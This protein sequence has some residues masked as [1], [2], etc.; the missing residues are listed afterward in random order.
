[1]FRQ[2]VV[3]KFKACACFSFVGSPCPVHL[4]AVL[5][6]KHVLEGSGAESSVPGLGFVFLVVS[7]LR[8]NSFSISESIVE[9]TVADPHV[10]NPFGIDLTSKDLSLS[11]ESVDELFA[12]IWTGEPNNLFV[13]DNIE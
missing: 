5:T 7:A 2:K 4:C 11:N 13:G 6:F 12:I 9:G 1:M 3:N 8:I 10:F